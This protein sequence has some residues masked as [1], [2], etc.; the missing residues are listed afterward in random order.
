MTKITDI[1][2]HW[3]NDTT[4]IGSEIESL[5]DGDTYADDLVT[6]LYDSEL[7]LTDSWDNVDWSMLDELENPYDKDR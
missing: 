7:E 5:D 1:D 4:L 6:D 3:L 2:N